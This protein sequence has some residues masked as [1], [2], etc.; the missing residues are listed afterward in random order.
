MSVGQWAGIL[1]LTCI[2]VVGLATLIFNSLSKK[3]GNKRNFS[4]AALCI[5]ITFD[6]IATLM[7]VN[8]FLP[9]WNT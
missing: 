3:E 2:P 9:T 1:L 4:R 5:R 6:I 7:V 8:G